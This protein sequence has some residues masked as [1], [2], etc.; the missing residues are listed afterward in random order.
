MTSRPSLR[1]MASA[2]SSQVRTVASGS[3]RRA[4]SRRRFQASLAENS[5]DS[6]NGWVVRQGGSLYAGMWKSQPC[7]EAL[8]RIVFPPHTRNQHATDVPP[9]QS[10]TQQQT[11]LPRPHEDSLGPCGP[12]PAAQEGSPADRDSH[13][14][15]AR[16]ALTSEGLPRSWRVSRGSALTAGVRGGGRRPCPP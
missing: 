7:P 3:S 10:A 8:A 16:S 9:A 2:G 11:R 15:Q 5:I 6:T 12:E 4:S 13:S 1:A 14:L